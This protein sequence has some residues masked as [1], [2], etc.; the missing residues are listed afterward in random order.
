MNNKLML[1]AAGVLIAIAAHPA[2]ASAGEYALHCEGA[3]ECTGTITGNHVE[4]KNDA[5]EAITCTTFEGSTSFTSTSTTG[6]ASLTFRECREQITFFHFKC[7]SPGLGSGHITAPNLTYHVINL[8]PSPGVKPG[9]KFTNV[10]VTFECAGYS[11][12][13]MTGSLVGEML[14]PAS[15]CNQSVTT[16]TVKFAQSSA[17][18]Q[19]WMQVTTTGTKTDL[20]TNDDAESAYT[21]SA[22]ITEGPIH[23]SRPVKIT[24]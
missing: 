13:T 24:C 11:T 3:V 10:A 4:L 1:L 14:N 20:V 19:Q 15:F 23:W 16:H 12:K 6:T 18:V 17:G 7:N 9:I 8:E 21:T 2:L 5:N 22:V